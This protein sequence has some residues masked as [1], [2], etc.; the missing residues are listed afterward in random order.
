[1][2]R[3]FRSGRQQPKFT[4]I[5]IIGVVLLVC[6][7][8]TV[9]VGTVA[10]IGTHRKKRDAQAVQPEAKPDPVVVASLDA[11]NLFMQY[12]TNEVAA[13]LAYKGQYIQVWGVVDRV[14]RDILDAPFVTLRV[15]KQFAI[16]KVQCFFSRESEDRIAKLAPGNFANI[17]GTC[18]GK[19]ANVILEG[20]RMMN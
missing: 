14:G 4:P 15:R 5:A 11:H 20:C 6:F 17:Y 3:D 18:K 8:F 19:M 10:S 9:V 13:D 2:T 16:F 7:V 1:M 12:D